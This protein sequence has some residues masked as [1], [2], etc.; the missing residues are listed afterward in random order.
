M[1][2]INKLKGLVVEIIRI[3]WDHGLYWDNKWLKMVHANW[4][5]F[6]VDFRAEQ[7]M[8]DVDKQIK[9]MSQEPKTKPPLY[10]EQEEG[11]TPLGGAFGYSYKF[12]DAP[13]GADPLQGPE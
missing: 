4:F 9:E 7:T 8:A 2:F 3:F 13:S 6:W 12:D 10:W 5:E 1:S 11:E